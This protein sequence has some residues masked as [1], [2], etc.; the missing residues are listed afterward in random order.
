VSAW[1]QF[2]RTRL[3]TLWQGSFEWTPRALALVR[4]SSPAGVWAM[5]GL[6]L[7]AALLPLLV[8]YVGKRIVDA[9][10]A[11][12]MEATAY[13]V[14]VE[15][16][17]VAALTLCTQG[18][19]VVRTVVGA[20]LGLDVNIRILEKATRLGLPQFED[21]EFYDRLT[22][23]RREA[24]ARPLSVVTRAFQ[25][26]QYAVSVL[27]YAVLLWQFSGW[28]VAALLLAAIPA[29][30]SEVR[31]SNQAFRLRNWR[32]ADT[33]K[34]LYLEHVLANDEY[35]KEVQLFGLGNPLLQR[36]RTLGEQ[37]YRED[38]GLALRRARWAYAL[39]LLA[40]GTFY[41]CYAVMGLAA[42]RG[43]LTLGE[44]TLDMVAFRQG[45][46][47]F[48]GLLGAL[49]GMYEDNLYMSN[50]FAYLDEGDGSAAIVPKLDAAR[51][52]ESSVPTAPSPVEHG[53][54]FEGVGFQYPGKKEFAL[55]HLDLFIP[56][57]QSLALVGQNGAGKTTFIKLLT[58]LYEPTEG[59]IFLD[60]VE[61]S[62]WNVDELRSRISV[63][64]Q[65]F[66]QYQFSLR[67]NVG[68][69]DVA[70][71][72]DAERINHA[73]AQG[74]AEQVVQSL[75][76]GIE[77]QLGK[78]FKQGVE[79]SGGQWQK[80][81]LARAFM[82]DRADILVLDEP[83]AA[84]DAEA[85][86]IVFE[87]FRELTKGKTSVL[88][89]HRFPTVRMADRILV[90]EKGIVVEDGSHA[91]LVRANGRYAHWFALQAQGYG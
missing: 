10:V 36:Y 76:E 29:T 58:R 8:A 75:P 90:V 5:A 33:R 17:V 32:S 87:R 42:A 91:E 23:A 19:S 30:V 52:V 73:V 26:A 18:Q 62:R 13:W 85:E 14:V 54:R 15:L 25:V 80:I 46:Q 71:L 74:G 12:Q 47:A 77:T 27:G 81:A 57:G 3:A 88:I 51:G 22:R 84:L 16:A 86:Q 35:A 67:E 39:S 55:R 72:A 82:R 38:R 78:W 64:F 65:D 43:Q 48:Q 2:I 9:V 69:G 41:A 66:S 83:T 61:L 7:I 6:T 37:F 20:R 44:L 60:G 53:I 79:L 40:T 34:L 63:V 11:R 68:F 28:V 45:Q 31:F 56:S 4:S 49:T 50:L 89:S 24:S 59:R 1:V 70:E 21:S